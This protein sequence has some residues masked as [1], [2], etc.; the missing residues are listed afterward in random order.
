MSSAT[1][2]AATKSPSESS[3]ALSKG[4][5]ILILMRHATRDHSGSDRLSA[6]GREMAMKLTKSVQEKRIPKPHRLIASPRKRTQETLRPLADD[7]LI[8]IE[9]ES[10]CD[11]RQPDETEASFTERVRN[12]IQSTQLCVN[13]RQEPETWLI[14]SHLDWLEVAVLF[15]ESDETEMEREEPWTPGAK[16]IYLK[17]DEIWRHRRS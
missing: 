2:K 17:T 4:S 13:S 11:E 15:L 9:I 3:R 6:E 12:F 16:R 8:P 7:L 10:R 1:S 5:P 14:V